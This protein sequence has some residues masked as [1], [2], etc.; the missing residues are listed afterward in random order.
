MFRIGRAAILSVIVIPGLAVAQ[1]VTDLGR[2]GEIAFSRIRGQTGDIY[3]V[4]ANG[5]GLRNLTQNRADE[6]DPSWSP[7]GRRIA[8][9][10]SPADHFADGD[11]YVMNADGSA[12]RRLTRT[13][14]DDWEPSWSPDGRRIAFMRAGG[15]NTWMIYVMSAD[16]STQPRLVSKSGFGPQ[17]SPDGQKIAFVR[18]ERVAPQS[19]ARCSLYVMNA[20]GTK[21]RRVAQRLGPPSIFA[22]SPSGRRI[23]FASAAGGASPAAPSKTQ[24]RVVSADGGRLRNPPRG[25]W[26]WG[27]SWSPD[28]RRIAFW[29]GD[30]D[31]GYPAS[32]EPRD[33]VIRVMNADGSRVRRLTTTGSVSLL[34]A[35][36]S[37]GKQIAFLR[38]SLDRTLWVTNPDGS[39]QRKLAAQVEPQTELVWKPQSGSM[40]LDRAN[41]NA[42]RTP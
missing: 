39:H 37:D 16:G 15:G 26:D 21:Q 4:N 22:W 36:S 27:P 20:D 10:R 8:F 12:Q 34:P 2:G 42:C 41:S 14:A 9:R 18:S 28:G 3:V 11:I 7:D 32:G 38:G 1:P 35:W 31:D 40:A 5:R 33:A 29:S 6:A 25:R 30:N 23:A 13:P 19:L 17:W 24:I